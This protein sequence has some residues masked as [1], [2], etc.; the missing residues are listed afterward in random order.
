M[1]HTELT[2]YLGIRFPILGAPM[3]G[4]AHG[5]LARAVTE[6][7]GL[8]MI[9]VGSTDGVDLVGRE[10]AVASDANRLPFGIGLM[11]WALERR[12]ELLEATI[13][14]RPTL[15]SVSFGS[16]AAYVGPLHDVGIVVASQAQDL[17]TAITAVGAPGAANLRIEPVQQARATGPAA[18]F[19]LT[20][21][22][23]RVFRHGQVLSHGVVVETDAG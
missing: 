16:L 22:Q 11:A 9:G 21:D 7:G 2:E 18:L 23:L 14:A 13:A 12:P 10:A 8:G 3:A 17:P 4:V 6:A 20:D 19:D 5:R 15:V 1:L